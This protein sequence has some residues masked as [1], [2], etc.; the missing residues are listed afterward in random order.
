MLIDNCS[1][2]INI[3]MFSYRGPLMIPSVLKREHL[4]HTLLRAHATRRSY[5]YGWTLL[6]S[7]SWNDITD[8]PATERQR[9]KKKIHIGETNWLTSTWPAHDWQN[10]NE[11]VKNMSGKLNDK[12]YSYYCT[13]LCHSDVQLQADYLSDIFCFLK[14]NLLIRLVC[15]WW[16]KSRLLCGLI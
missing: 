14:Y 8:R 12:I 15:L 1:L 6:L 9:Q 16:V 13:V 7:I 4:E 10:S 11:W 3:A 5:I 2:I